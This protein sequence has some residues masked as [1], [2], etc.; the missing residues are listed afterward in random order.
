MTTAQPES[1]AA[2]TAPR[3]VGTLWPA[4]FTALARA[5]RDAGSADGPEEALR[6]L[7]TVCPVVLGDKDAHL[8]PGGLR[9]G[10]RQFSIAGAFMLTPDRR[11]NLLVA[12]V[13][14][15]AEQHRLRIDADLAHPGWVVKH[16]QPLILANTD[17]DADF[18]QIL[19]TARMGSAL[20]A[21]IL[22]KGALLGQLVCASQARNTYE[23]AD[24]DVLVALAAAGAALWI[25]HGG[26]AFLE[27]IA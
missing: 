10:E 3:D 14:F 19:K 7:T 20:Y 9:A 23:P 21:P 6:Q 8:R 18:K 25:A 15:P 24:L 11:H 16:R 4:A 12:E 17:R 1:L 22:W 27:Q 13:G 2:G 26:A 5:I